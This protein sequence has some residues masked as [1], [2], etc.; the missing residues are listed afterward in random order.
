MN[1]DSRQDMIIFAVIVSF[2][3]HAA[4]MFFIRPQVMTQV[5]GTSGTA[6]RREIVRIREAEPAPDA[7]AMEAVRDIEALRDSPTAEAEGVLPGAAEL[8]EPEREAIPAAPSVPENTGVELAG[9][10][11]APFMSEKIHID[12]VAKSNF[13]TPI[14]EA[15]PPLAGGAAPE[16]FAADAFGSGEIPLF[17]AP[18]VV[19]SPAPR[20][21][22]ESVKIAQIAGVTEPKR[23]FQASAEVMP[24]VDEKIVE[25]EKA[26]VRDLLDVPDAK[27]LSKYVSVTAQSA[28]E[29]SDGGGWLYFRVRISPLDEL[30]IVPKDVVVL[31]DASGSIGNDRLRS[32]RA[33]AHDILRSATNTGDRFNL[34]AFRDRFQYAFK[35]WQEISQASLD[36]ADKWLWSLAAHG[37][38]DVFRVIRSVLALPRDPTRPL[39]ALVVTDGD[40]NSGVSETAQILS[41]FTA[42]N[43]G[44]VSVYMYGV[45]E[46][47]NRELID[48]LTHG[49]RG[50]S[51]IYGGSRWKAGTK[52]E[53]LSERFR[54][55]VLSDLRVVFAAG[56][57]AEAYPAR[58][59]NLY[60]GET[61]D[62][63]GRLPKGKTQVAF[64]IKGLNGEKSYEAFF[65]VDL[66]SVAFD[67]TLP[68]NWRLERG[69]D[70]KLR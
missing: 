59:K 41:R 43:D 58:L 55:P 68:A 5:A 61:V 13:S 46:S 48:V 69:I 62:I 22:R 54:D 10:E 34:V 11:V 64:S 56:S 44:L 6:P 17:T 16:F 4:T 7:I 66:A 31:L 50:E 30:K 27:E 1:D 37:R 19:Y 35:S 36:K 45:K 9:I 28:S 39:I 26:A 15:T 42:L 60:R 49:N 67:P 52:I 2:V 14:A 29:E 57:Q 53:S 33:A 65:K 63:I 40:A 47:A 38:T 3:V 8:S 25:A 21:E 23:D 24:T 12:N 20:L 70:E 51:F 32:C 18:A